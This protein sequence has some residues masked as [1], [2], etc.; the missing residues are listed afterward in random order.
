MSLHET[1]VAAKKQA[2][3]EFK[4]AQ[5]N[6]LKELDKKIKAT[7]D[8]KAEKKALDLALGEVGL[9]QGES[10][11]DYLK[12]A[13]GFGKALDAFENAVENNTKL[14]A[15]FN[16]AHNVDNVLK[17]KAAAK[18]LLL[19]CQRTHDTPM[20]TFYMKDYKKSAAD[21]WNEYVK[22]GSPNWIDVSVD[23]ALQKDWQDAAGDPDTLN[24]LG[25]KLINRLRDHVHNELNDVTDK[26]ERD[27][28]ASKNLGFVPSSTV[29]ALKKEVGDTAKKYD[30]QIQ[31]AV[32]KWS[33]LKPQFWRPL[34]GALE[35]IKLY[36]EQH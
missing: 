14:R 25:P 11:D 33:K 5:K 10:L 36:A 22:V 20:I 18:E 24:S 3:K 6:Y 21:I 12:F 16:F 4:E 1:W 23:G 8:A 31:D 15:K 17:D 7:R 30:Q 13:D 35:Q 34:D 29:A 2:W 28:T 27:P 32:D 9:D 19:F 26:L